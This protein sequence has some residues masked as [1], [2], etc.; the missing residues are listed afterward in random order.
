MTE[1]ER[2]QALCEEQRKQIE[3]YCDYVNVNK[4][5]IKNFDKLVKVQGER[6]EELKAEAKEWKH[7][8]AHA[9]WIA[10]FEFLVLFTE[11][12]GEII[13]S[14]YVQS[15]FKLIGITLT[16]EEVLKMAEYAA[17][18]FERDAEYTKQNRA[19]SK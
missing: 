12:K 7:L 1:L 9:Q 8:Y 10:I 2:L 15:S 19:T 14:T 6:I 3:S 18:H 16:I 4:E 13:N 11:S 5:L 17:K